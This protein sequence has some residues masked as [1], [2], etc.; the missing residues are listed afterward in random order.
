MK[1]LLSW[2]KLKDAKDDRAPRH[3]HS[4]DFVTIKFHAQHGHCAAETK[5]NRMF[6]SQILIGS[7]IS[8]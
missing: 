3:D 2:N 7:F 5:M 8:C 1:E 6:F 4:T